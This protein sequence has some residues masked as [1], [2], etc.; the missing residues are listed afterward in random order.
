M[1]AQTR[2]HAA[3]QRA[4]PKRVLSVRS[5]INVPSVWIDGEVSSRRE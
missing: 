1:H 4:E 5:E 3:Q 2:T